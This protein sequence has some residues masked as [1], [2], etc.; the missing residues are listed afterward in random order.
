MREALS[1]A[2]Q[3]PAGRSEYKIG[4]VFYA[5][6][7]TAGDQSLIGR[8]LQYRAFFL[9]DLAEALTWL[10]SLSSMDRP[11]AERLIQEF[12]ART[13]EHNV[14]LQAKFTFANE[15]P[16]PV[17]DLVCARIAASFRYALYERPGQDPAVALLLL[18]KLLSDQYWA[19]AQH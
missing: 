11:Q 3:Q 8:V 13:Q 1:A 18:K 17:N 9:R 6:G 5:D 2:L 14:A 19:V 7:A 12:D 16:F 10:E 15:V 4:A